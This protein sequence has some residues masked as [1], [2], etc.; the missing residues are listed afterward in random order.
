MPSPDEYPPSETKALHEINKAF[1][2]YFLSDSNES[3]R[4]YRDT[5]NNLAEAI[6]TQIAG[7]K[8][9][10][11]GKSPAALKEEISALELFPE[12]G[13]SLEHV[14]QM[15]QDLVV[16]SN[17]SVYHPYCLAHLHCPTFIA[18]LAAEMVISA[19][20]QSMDSWDQ[21]PAA[22]MIE[23]ALCDKLCSIYGFG[24]EADA[25]FTSGGTMSNFMGLLLARDH[26]SEKNLEWN[27]QKQGV[28]GEFSKFRI[29]SS[30]HAHFTVEQSAAILGLGQDAV[31]KIINTTPEEDVA[32][33]RNTI[34]SLLAQGLMPIAYVTTAGT[35]DYGSIGNIDELADC[36]HQYGLWIHVD[37]AYGGA[38]MFSEKHK[39]KLRG[40]EKVDSVTVDFHKLF[41]QPISCS[42]IMVK[43]KSMFEYIRLHADYL[44]PEGNED[45]G[46]IDL[47]SKSIQTTRRFDALKP[48]I[49]MQH[50]GVKKL[51]EMIDYTIWLAEEASRI[52][53]N[54]SQFELAF[55]TQINAVVFRYMPTKVLNDAAVDSINNKIKM[56]F[57]LSGKAIIGQTC[58]KER[59]Y[60]K[61]TLLN[62]MTTIE[63]VTS[64]LQEIKQAGK[65]LEQ[66]F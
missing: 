4:T 19:F 34:E 65:E 48:F 21:A 9:P 11:A 40:I 61:C 12:T 33:L 22:T 38:L 15:T 8:Q 7:Q 52:I 20:N 63:Q 54:D 57:L 60:M 47:V 36:A 42:M 29:I 30:Q 31:V 18:S 24:K 26:Y 45:Y 35:T 2:H 59:A 66:N 39:H 64:L 32:L 41:Y 25:T 27:I 10:Y 17:I 14:L 51:G 37:A 53:E 58:V 43:D 44:N 23:Q 50:V 46:I 5:V 16:K 55:K 13:N 1:K 3:V 49:A 56:Q 6:T 28:P 62:P